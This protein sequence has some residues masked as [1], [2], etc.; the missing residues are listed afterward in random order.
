[1]Q[2]SFCPTAF[3]KLHTLTAEDDK[4]VVEEETKNTFTIFYKDIESL[5]AKFISSRHSPDIYQVKINYRNGNNFVVRSVSFKGFGKTED[6]ASTYSPFIVALHQKIAAA[7]SKVKFTKG[8]SKGMSLFLKLFGYFAL[9]LFAVIA[10]GLLFSGVYVKGIIF[11]VLAVFTLLR[12]KK[13]FK[14]NK[15]VTYTV[16]E[17]PEDIL[18]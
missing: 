11:S 1:M 14:L 10:L 17:I 15:A 3:K 18:P 13:F 5:N 7:N 2:Y 6:Q 12:L 8:Y 16:D 4:L 9:V